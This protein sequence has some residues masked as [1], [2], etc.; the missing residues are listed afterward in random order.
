MAGLITIS[1]DA[2]KELLLLSKM[3]KQL[4][5]RLS[6]MPKHQLLPSMVI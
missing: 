6:M 4:L 5:H 1:A 3:P 2:P